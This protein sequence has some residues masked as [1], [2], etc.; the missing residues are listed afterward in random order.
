[1]VIEIKNPPSQ[2]LQ[3]ALNYAAKG[4]SVIPIKP[5]KKPFIK[6]EPHQKHKATAEE[7]QKL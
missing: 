7:A 3:A 1:M 5:N 4:F 2:I 6:W